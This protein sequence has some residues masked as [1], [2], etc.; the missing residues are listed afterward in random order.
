LFRVA[1]LRNCFESVLLCWFQYPR[2]NF[3]DCGKC[4]RLILPI[5]GR[6]INTG[7]GTNYQHGGGGGGSG[8]G[9]TGGGFAG[10]VSVIIDFFALLT[11]MMV[12]EE[13]FEA[14]VSGL[15][16][17]TNVTAMS[18]MIVSG[19]LTLVVSF[20]L[21]LLLLSPISLVVISATGGFGLLPR[22][23]FVMSSICCCIILK[24]SVTASCCLGVVV[25]RYR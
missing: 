4:L 8:G 23:P 25:K 13:F 15:R 19:L 5:E 6:G 10:G 12:R 3:R 24:K 22:A 11:L 17:D 20:P 9:G 18:A 7:V 14:G 21:L 2:Y 16:G 1:F